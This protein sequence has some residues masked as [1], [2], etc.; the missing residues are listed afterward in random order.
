MVNARSVPSVHL[1]TSRLNRIE[2]PTV[3]KRVKYRALLVAGDTL[4]LLLLPPS[5]FLSAS[6]A[7]LSSPAFHPRLTRPSQEGHYKQTRRAPGYFANPGP[8]HEAREVDE[9]HPVPLLV[10]QPLGLL[11]HLLQG[12]LLGHALGERRGVCVD[13]P[14]ASIDQS[15]SW[16]QIHGYMAYLGSGVPPVEPRP[17]SLVRM[18]EAYHIRLILARLA[19]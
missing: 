13:L 6:S 11:K 16:V 2:Y 14:R 5:L 1:S 10:K 7:C 4:L 8:H 17:S 9:T 15:Y 18:V 19:V 12:L 3:A